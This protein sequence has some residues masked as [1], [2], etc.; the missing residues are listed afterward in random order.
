[1]G[2]GDE[3][4]GSGMARGA[5]AR[6]KR[7]AFGDGKHIIWSAEAR[8]IYRDNPNV[9]PPHDR[10]DD[11][12]EWVPHYKGSRLY[13][14]P[15]DGRWIFNPEFRAIPGE[16][17]FDYQERQFADGI[18][19]GFVLIEPNIKRRTAGYKQWPRDRYQRV[20]DMLRADGHRVAQFNTG[21]LLVGV[22][23]IHTPNFRC[24]VAAL[25]R[26]ALYIGPEG[27]LHHGAAAMGRPA[28]VIFGGFVHPRT[29]GYADHINLFVGD[30][31]C[32]RLYQTCDHCRQ[33]MDAISVEKVYEAARGRLA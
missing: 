26:A 22:E 16:I 11:D 12:L 29:T 17:F 33:A 1:M 10:S 28:V 2:L 13:G 30:E 14:V 32:G 9:A 25:G 20:A 8:E 6:G 31:P 3:L 15:G 21:P 19:P 5:K 18:P 24:A 4:L 23:A 7:I 27:G